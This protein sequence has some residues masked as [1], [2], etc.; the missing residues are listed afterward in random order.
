MNSN[1]RKIICIVGPTASGK[2]GIGVRFARELNGEI[3]SADSR[4][5]FRG[6]NIG[7]GKEY[8]PDVK[9]WLIDIKEPGE[10]FSVFDW[11][12]L[13]RQAIEDIFSR[14]KV[15]IVVGGTGLY[16]QALVE[17][18][19]LQGIRNEELGIGVIPE[20]FQN[21][22]EELG[23]LLKELDPETYKKVDKHNPHRLIRAIERAREGLRPAKVKPDFEV[24]QIGIDLPRAELYRRIDKRVDDRFKQ[25]MLEE[26]ERLIKSGV[27][28]AWLIK[29]G[30]EYRIITE[31]ILSKNDVTLSDSEG[32]R[33]DVSARMRL[34]L[35]SSAS[36]QNDHNKEFQEMSQKLKFR[37][38]AFAR[39]QLTWFR[40]FPGIV[41]LDDYD[42]ILTSVK[43]FLDS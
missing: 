21:N 24:L 40:R 28:S 22:A 9:Q 26:V 34:C 29:L 41:W 2:T 19:E 38:H 11:L 6:L 37:I 4:Q 23:K 15:P 10:K 13:A 8:F 39:R 16:V 18:F 20:Q 30:L 12:P 3:V 5:I 31:Y 1:D 14:G 27:D 43:K 7:S 36:P 42:K 17:G 32:S 25:G 35:D 33:A